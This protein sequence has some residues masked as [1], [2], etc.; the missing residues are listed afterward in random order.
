MISTFASPKFGFAFG[1]VVSC[2][3]LSLKKVVSLIIT[4]KKVS[5]CIVIVIMPSKTRRKHTYD[6]QRYGE[7]RDKILA[8]RKEAYDTNSESK[9][10]ASKIASKKAYNKNP[11]AKKLVSKQAYER[12]PAYNKLASKQ[13]YGRNP[14]H[15]KLSSKQA[16]LKDST[17][18]KVAALSRYHSKSDKIKAQRRAKYQNSS[19]Q[20]KVS[21]RVWYLKNTKV[22]TQ[23]CMAYYAKHKEIIS[24]TRRN[25][26]YLSPPKSSV[27]EM[28]INELIRELLANRKART[29]VM[30]AFKEQPIA[31]RLARISYRVACRIAARRLVHEALKKRKEYAAELIKSAKSINAKSM[32]SRDDFGEGIHCK[33]S[34]DPYFYEASYV[35]DDDDSDVPDRIDPSNQPRDEMPC[36]S[37]CK[38]ITDDEVNAIVRLKNA[39]TLPMHELRQALQSCDDCPNERQMM[40]HS[41]ACHQTGSMC[42]S[43]LR[44]LRAASAHHKVL[45]TFM[46]RVYRA[47][48]SHESLAGID[49]ALGEGDFK[50]LLCA[51]K[52][53]FD[54]LLTTN[55]FV[56]EE[57]SS[58]N[59]SFFRVLNLETTLQL[60]HSL[61]IS[62]LEKEWNDDAENVCCSCQCLF[63]R[64]SV[65]KAN[66][67]KHF[68]SDIGS[69]LVDY[70]LK[71]TP[72]G[73]DETLY[74]CSYCKPKI[75]ADVLPP[76]CVL[77]GLETIPIPSEL[78][79]LDALSKQFIQ[80]A[81]CFQTV[82]RLGTYTCKVPV[83]NSLKA[84]KGSVFFLPLP[85]NKTCETLSNV[86]GSAKSGVASPELYILVNGKPTKA[87]VVWRSLVNIERVKAAIRKLKEIHK[88][89]KSVEADSL[90]ETTQKVIEVANNATTKM[91]DKATADDIAGYQSYTIRYLDNQIPTVSDIDQYKLVNVTEAPIHSR[92]KD[93]DVMCFPVLYPNGQFGENHPRNKEITLSFSEFVKQRL[94]NKDSRFRKD[95]SYVFYLLNQKTL[96]EVGNGVYNVLHSSRGV[97][98]S[99]KQLL[100]KV[101]ASDERLEASLFTMLQSVRGSKQYWWQRKSDLKCMVRNWGSPTLFLTFSCA[102]YEWSDMA[103]YLRK[104]NNVS[105]SYDMGRLCTEDP[106]SVSRKFSEKFHAFFRIVI[107]KGQILGEVEHFY[108]KKEYQA[109]GAPHYHV[110]LWIKDA[111]VIGCD[112]S[113]VVLKWIQERVTCHIP[114]KKTSPELHELVTRYQMHKCSAYCKR[115]RKVGSTFITYC[116]F[117]FPRPACETGIVHSVEDSLKTRKKIYELPRTESEVRVNDYNPLIL[118]LWKANIDIQFVSESSLALAHYVSGYVTKAERSNMQ[119]IWRE[120]QDS[121][122]IYSK[123]YKFGMKALSSRECGLYEAAD[124]LLGDH[125]TEK[126]EAIQFV[127][128][129]MPHK[130]NRRL[131]SHAALTELSKSDPDSEDLFESNLVDTYY[132]N[133]PNKLEDVCLYDIVANYSWYHTIVKGVKQTEFKRRGKPV[134]PNHKLYDLR[135]EN[136]KE[137]YYYSLIMLFVPFRNESELLLEDE[138][139]E[140]A[141][142]RHFPDTGEHRCLTHHTRLQQM[143]ECNRSVKLINEARQSDCPE[144]K[145]DNEPQLICEAVAAMQDAV[146]MVTKCEDTLSLSDRTNMLNADQR[147]IFDKVKEHM[148]HLQQHE[149]NDCSCDLPPL[150]M[151]VT[152]VAGTGKSFLIE[153]IKAFVAQLWP[154]ADCSCA[155]TA[156]TGLAAF[157]V[158]G[159]TIHRLFQLPVQHGG[160]SAVHWSLPKAAHKVMKTALRNVKLFI[161]DEI[162]MVSS[163]NLAY[164][165]LR[166]NELYGG[167]DYFGARNMIVFGDLLQL[168]PVGGQPVFSPVPDT[169]VKYRIGCATSPNIWEETVVYDELT[170]NERQKGD[171][172]Y[173]TLL[174]GIR[175]GEV[176]SS[177]ISTLQSRVFTCSLT[178]K[179][180]ELQEQGIM[181]VTF[182]PTRKQCDELNNKMLKS[183]PGK[184]FELECTDDVDETVSKLKWTK[185]ADK[186]LHKLNHDCNMTGGLQ[187]VLVLA[188]GARVMLRRNV[189]TKK[190]LVNG[191][192]GT[193]TAITKQFVTVQFDHLT[194]PYQVERVKSRFVVMKN[195][196]V[197]REQFPL[198]L[199]Y[200]VTIHKSQGLSLDHAIIDLS[201]KV[202]CAAMAY[203]ALSR[204]RSLTGLHLLSFDPKSIIVS[205]R[206]LEE[207]NRLRK[208]YRPD[209]P[210][211]TIPVQQASKR[212]LVGKPDTDQVDTVVVPSKK[213]KCSQTTTKQQ[214]IP[215]STLGIHRKRTSTAPVQTAKPAKRACNSSAPK[216]Q[217]HTTATAQN[218]DCLITGSFDPARTQRWPYYYY[219]VDL[220]WQKTAC[221]TL[222]LEHHHPPPRHRGGGANVPLTPPDHNHTKDIDGDGNCM[223][224]SFS[225]VIT[226]SQAQHM[227][228][229]QAILD[230]MVAISHLLYAHQYDLFAGYSS[231]QQ[232]IE[233]TKMNQNETWGSDIEIITLSHLINTCIFTYSTQDQNWYRFSPHSVDR[234]LPDDITQRAMYLRYLPGHYDVVLRTLSV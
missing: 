95:A 2:L 1:F 203:V 56:G 166:L 146:S 66:F 123:L 144:Q 12:N 120:I 140:E 83:Y 24:H 138:T 199:A 61:V 106:I 188:I 145:V 91:L 68:D 119:D 5:S 26:Y 215:V 54:E 174:N 206:S 185:T 43:E 176:T 134:L 102:E 13:A 229:R 111:P 36:T 122:S 124:L 90:D 7:N 113:A 132:P 25:K 118:L 233:D 22:K 46:R 128:V 162:S 226:G 112:D 131:K 33:R 201:D 31:K 180:A 198:I 8:G 57:G 99:V 179:I 168:E 108:W 214:T 193:V 59:N 67:S 137:D 210:L 184:S 53:S 159:M 148:I 44:I 110:L 213:I 63:Q 79:K 221:A 222:G 153:T 98:M 191:S 9:K 127:N 170:I 88:L 96:R 29:E 172:D 6:K 58:I 121:K 223:F 189:D 157:N 143:L 161:V 232:Y 18:K 218:D 173:A 85:F 21:S 195:Y 187:S 84:C 197:R 181:V 224:R 225:Y 94:H 48:A 81:K 72:P 178:E 17:A 117:G 196:Y 4:L 15:K 216:K 82:V 228:V 155:I 23:A 75:K 47:K 39:F 234:T 194:S 80:L 116:K 16:Y 100:A 65:T 89:Y 37:D 182:F 101:E 167:V 183:L 74:M 50:H 86:E 73:E 69:E 230:H 169:V 164:I 10:V 142:N 208:M 186:Q 20:K 14:A 125:L 77:N 141:F 105:P 55:D 139:A 19:H 136:Q 87:N 160:R 40:G 190:G 209:L 49:R 34:C 231:V 45:R 126:S 52:K 92:L 147:R 165:H 109:R 114:D 150:C 41:L 219:P 70:I 51:T 149:T 211:Y 93:L 200:A 212:K 28:Y 97:A 156:P 171:K 175:I 35:K 130:R 27:K 177:T 217:L 104:V 60:Q 107:C 205:N 11:A 163:L 133:R 115:R 42:N 3:D 207:Y 103:R 38:P 192:L 154:S 204:V 135:N 32:K 220:E 202:F 227:A 62:Q 158:G 71:H 64:K 78:D 76:R 129:S 30:K 152:G 151:F